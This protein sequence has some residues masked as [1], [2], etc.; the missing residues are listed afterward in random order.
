MAVVKADSVVRLL[1]RLRPTGRPDRGPRSQPREPAAR[2]RPLLSPGAGRPAAASR[3]P[4]QPRG[5]AGDDRPPFAQVG[6]AHTGVIGQVAQG[7]RGGPVNPASWLAAAGPG[8]VPGRHLHQ[9]PPSPRERPRLG[10]GLL[11]PWPRPGEA[12]MTKWALVPLIPNDLTPAIR[13]RPTGGAR[14]ALLPPGRTRGYGRWAPEVQVGRD[15]AWLNHQH[16]LDQP[17]DARGRLEVAE[18]RL[19]RTEHAAE[20]AGRPVAS[21]RPGRATSIGSP[22]RR[23]GAVG[24]DVLDLPRLRRRPAQRPP[25]HGLL[26][27]AVGRGQAVAP[28]VL[29]DGRAADDREN[30]VAGG[31]AWRAA[32]APRCRSPRRGRSRPAA[33]SKVL[34]RPSADSIRAWTARWSI[35]GEQDQ[36]DAAGQG[37]VAL[38]RPQALAGQVHRDQRRRARRVQ[39]HARSPQPE[40]VRQPPTGEIEGVPGAP[41]TA[42]I[43]S[44]LALSRNF[45]HSQQR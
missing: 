14:S 7:H 18:V 31:H 41:C 32:S 10:S 25:D 36:V 42:S 6:P 26:G 30:A 44:R 17:G 9:R 11:R 21:T 43:M 38:A 20:A 35:S 12:S 24:L 37:Q 4:D 3:G 8:R 29:V 45:A 34:Q 33:A 13:G 5:D 39:G 19:D 2:P 23:A 22:R 1:G 40:Q 28:A 15:L 16:R 27:R